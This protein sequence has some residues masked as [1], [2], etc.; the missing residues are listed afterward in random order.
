MSTATFDTRSRTWFVVRLFF[1]SIGVLVIAAIVYPIFAPVRTSPR[2][3]SVLSMTKQ[4]A[5]GFHIYASD[6]DDR[7]PHSS[8]WM[9]DLYPYVGGWD[10]FRTD[11]DPN[12]G[13]DQYGM[14]MNRHVSGIDLTVVSDKTVL[15]FTSSDFRKNAVGGPEIFAVVER[16]EAG[17]VALADG[18]ASSAQPG[19]VH[20][21]LALPAAGSPYDRLLWLD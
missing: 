18:S 2:R 7:L 20:Q 13:D 5:V 19:D 16:F 6:F 3:A 10:I 15:N 4:I 8:A 17:A 12:R 14:A 21:W 9:D 1:Y 11:F